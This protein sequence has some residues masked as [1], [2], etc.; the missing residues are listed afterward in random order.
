MTLLFVA[1]FF[2]FLRFF[3]RYVSLS[4]TKSKRCKS[5][6]FTF[7]DKYEVG[8]YSISGKAPNLKRFKHINRNK[9][10]MIENYL[11]STKYILLSKGAK[12]KTKP[13]FSSKL[14]VFITSSPSRSVKRILAP[15]IPSFL[16]SI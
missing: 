13:F 7:G 2:D 16:Q 15:L 9:K 10:A 6:Y 5:S 12:S 14:E 11:F 4:R 3:C 1:V 8:G